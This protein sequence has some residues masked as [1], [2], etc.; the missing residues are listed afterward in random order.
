MKL[1]SSY[2]KSKD[3]DCYKRSGQNSDRYYPDFNHE[4]NPAFVMFHYLTKGMPEG[5]VLGDLPPNA[6]RDTQDLTQE[7]DSVSQDSDDE[8]VNDEHGPSSFKRPASQRLVMD[9]PASSIASSASALRGRSRSRGRG[10]G[11]ESFG[12]AG[13]TLKKACDQLLCS[14]EKMQRETERQHRERRE[15]RVDNGTDVMAVP[16]E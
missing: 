4:N 12:E 13:R 3:F 14:F 1:R 2:E 15:E 6:M 8:G 7:D 5:S 11:T 16:I 10:R 9:S